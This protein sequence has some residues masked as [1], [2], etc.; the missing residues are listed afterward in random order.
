[1]IISILSLI[2]EAFEMSHPRC[3]GCL[4]IEVARVEMAGPFPVLQGVGYGI[5][6]GHGRLFGIEVQRVILS[7]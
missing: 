7:E 5:P 2:T 3:G 6:I 4:D 1:L